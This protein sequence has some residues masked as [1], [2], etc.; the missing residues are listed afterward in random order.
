M[1]VISCAST[2]ILSGNMSHQGLSR[3]SI[4]DDQSVTHVCQ[5]RSPITPSI[6][7]WHE[8]LVYQ[9]VESREV[10]LRTQR[11][12]FDFL[13]I[14]DMSE[15]CLINRLRFSLIEL[16]LCFSFVLDTISPPISVQDKLVIVSPRHS[17]FITRKLL[18]WATIHL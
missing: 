13:D 14:P 6:F 15:I 18:A 12:A 5:L 4:L 10:F 17:R 3:V 16:V 8:S 7:D 1:A 9:K 2:I 11:K